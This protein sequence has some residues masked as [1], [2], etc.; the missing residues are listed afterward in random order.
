[1]T[2]VSGDPP[3]WPDMNAYIF[4]SYFGVAALVVVVYDWALTFGQEVELIW[5]QRLSPM[6]V[7]YLGVRYLGIL[8]ATLSM[9][10]NVPA[11]SLTDTK[12]F[13]VYVVW[14]WICAVAFAMLWVITITRL[15][16]MYQ[17]SRKILIFL[18]VTFLAVNIFS[19]MVA[20]MITMHSSAEELILSGTY[21]CSFS[22]PEYILLLSSITWIL[23]TVFEVV[24]LCLAVWITVKHFR[25]LRRHSAG[26]IIGDCF[27]VLLRSHVLYFASFVVSACFE[28]ISD[29]SPMAVCQ[30]FTE[31]RPL[32][33]TMV[34][35]F[36]RFNIP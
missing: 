29:F 8:Y 1:M 12:C 10:W 25:E 18:I 30:S 34:H 22:Y 35:C 20:V 19:V 28:L 23:V 9:L 27:E 31:L 4:A 16:A 32:H 14:N 15:H 11:T 3:W 7:M 24:A 5:R 33:K 26:G 21:Q 2:V 36:Y 17:R 6:T 13:I